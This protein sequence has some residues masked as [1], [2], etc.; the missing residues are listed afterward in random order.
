MFGTVASFAGPHSS[1]STSMK[2]EMHDEA[3]QVVPE[4]QQR[5]QRRTRPMSHDTITV[6]RFQRSTSAP[7]TGASNKPG[8]MRAVITRPMANPDVDTLPAIAMIARKPDPVAEAR[9]EL[10]AEERR[11]PGHT[12]DR[13]TAW[14]G[15][16]PRREWGE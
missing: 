5:E 10:R 15:S 1:V 2:N 13:A 7:P 4:R 6:L 16:A 14:A 8:S 12:E 9:D 11:E 3:E